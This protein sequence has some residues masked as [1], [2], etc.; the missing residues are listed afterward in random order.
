M[1]RSTIAG[2][3]HVELAGLGLGIVYELGDCLGRN[4]RIYLHDKGHADDACN[5]RDVTEKNE[6]ELFVERRVDC[7]PRID[8]EERIAIRGRI[9]DHLGADITAS[10]RAVL[11]DK[12]LAEP[13][14]QPLAHQTRGDVGR[15][16]GRIAD[17]PA[18]PPRRIVLRHCD[19]RYGRKRGSARCQMKK[20]TAEKFHSIT[21][22]ARTLEERYHTSLCRSVT[23][24]DVILPR[25]GSLFFRSAK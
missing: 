22:S 17:D 6:I 5:R 23:D 11:N 20:L 7:V 9:H 2:R 13:L 25:N 1:L 3:R 15:A 19:A 21:S 4:R 8:Q 14:R 16:A 18:H 10:A 24:F 12:W